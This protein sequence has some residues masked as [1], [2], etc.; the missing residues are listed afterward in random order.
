MDSNGMDLCTKFSD[1]SSS[2][3]AVNGGGNKQKHDHTTRVSFLKNN[4]STQN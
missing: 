2:D 4:E 3:L 1:K